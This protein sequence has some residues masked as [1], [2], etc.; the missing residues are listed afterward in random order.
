[1]TEVE[2]RPV[3]GYEGHYEVDSE[4]NISSLKYGKRRK[5]AKR[6]N[7]K[8]YVTVSLCT[9]GTQHYHT[10]HRIV[11]QA[12]ITNP[13]GLP[14][15]NHKDENKKNNRVENLEWCTNTYNSHYSQNYIKGG[16]A[17]Q[18]PVYAI[19]LNTGDIT[20][21]SAIHSAA[22]ALGITNQEICAVLKGKQKQ[23]HGYTFEYCRKE[24]T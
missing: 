8:G 17:R 22:R 6:Y 23:S 13:Q 5:L 18:K 7:R 16:A 4:G 12:F 2:V 21:H 10:V 11:A 3:V 1:M 24:N 20:V 14:Q 15:V 19:N 9:N